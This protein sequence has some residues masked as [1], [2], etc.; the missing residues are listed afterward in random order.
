MSNITF[1]LLRL[2]IGVSMFG[3][4]LVR[5]PKLPG[6]SKW[7]VGLFEKSIMPTALV[8]PFSYILPV[9][10]FTTGLLI[11]TGLFTKAALTSAAV[12]MLL[13]LFGTTLIESWDSIPSQLIHLTLLA[14]LAGYT[15]TYNSYA[16]DKLIRK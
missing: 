8:T 13:L 15:P 1:L 4:G 16:L 10:E 5:L 2:G 9:A 14:V 6:F 11:I 7:M 12:V 3:H